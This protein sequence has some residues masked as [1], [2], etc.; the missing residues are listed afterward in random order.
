[1]PLGVERASCGLG[2]LA[3]AF[4]N[5]P[6]RSRYCWNPSRGCYRSFLRQAVMTKLRLGPKD[7]FGN[8]RPLIR[9]YASPPQ[10]MQWPDGRSRHIKQWLGCG[11]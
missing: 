8:I 1:M 3:R 7:C 11:N 9:G 6:C 5:I 4:G 2:L 10:A